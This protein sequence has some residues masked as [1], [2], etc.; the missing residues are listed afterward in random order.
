MNNNL[1]YFNEFGGFSEDGKEYII[2]TNEKTTP[3]PW[4]HV[5]ANKDFGTILTENGG[6]YIWYK[7]SQANKITTW[8]NDPLKDMPSE[9]L[10]L[11][12]QNREID[13]L[14]YKSLE[15]FEVIYGFGYAKFI[16]QDE[17]IKINTL[18]YVPINR[19]KKVYKVMIESKEEINGTFEYLMEPV[20]GV[21]REFTKK[22]IVIEKEEDTVILKN[23]YRELYL[24]DDVLLKFSVPV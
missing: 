11:K 7:N 6:G 9:K 3:L 23:K 2:K 19:S 24:D 10:I 22:H 1:L 21:S 13:I 12:T 4:S 14:P 5:I 8:S 15:K 17:D 16:Y 18:I 20:L